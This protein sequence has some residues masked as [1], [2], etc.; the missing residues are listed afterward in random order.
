MESSPGPDSRPEL[1]HT[2]WHTVREF[3]GCDCTD[4][5]PAA[6]TGSPLD[7][8]RAGPCGPAPMHR[9]CP[10]HHMRTATEHYEIRAAVRARKNDAT[11][12][13]RDFSAAAERS[14]HPDGAVWAEA[15]RWAVARL[16]GGHASLHADE[17]F[18]KQ[19]GAHPYRSAWAQPDRPDTLDR[20]PP[21]VPPSCRSS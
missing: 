3:L 17:T 12:V 9:R 11:K 8:P 2:Q 20:A 4:P 14:P 21:I 5:D 1:T 19:F 10:C 7:T 6:C 15:L 16:T 13:L 18:E